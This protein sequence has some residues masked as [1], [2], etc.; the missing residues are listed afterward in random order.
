MD[1]EPEIGMRP[2]GGGI[3]PVNREE[4]GG[5]YGVVLLEKH[6][7]HTSEPTLQDLSEALVAA[8]GTDYGVH[9]PTWISRFTDMTRQA[10]SYREGR[11]LLAGDAAHVHGPQGGQGLNT[12]VQ[13]AVNL[14]WKL[15]QVVNK[16]SPESL[17]DTYH[18]ER[19]PVGARVLQ[20]T[21]AQVALSRIDERSQA[22]R[23][24][25][26][27]TA[28]HGRAAHA[29]RR[30]DLRSRHPLRPR[31]GTPAARAAHAR[32]RRAH[33]GRSH[34]R[35]HPAARRPARAPQPR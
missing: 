33:R 9:S 20:N 26:L 19:H 15:A 5:P 31:R 28:E 8:Y 32:P 34:A 11:V 7:E 30:D 18:A 13:D 27:D 1:E 23:D 12:G 16:T 17:L 10:A 29:H 25:V 4:G 6:V 35:L 14:G 22:L 2:E 3:G 24:T 21:M